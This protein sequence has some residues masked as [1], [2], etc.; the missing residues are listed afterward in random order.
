MQPGKTGE[1]FKE[2]G[3][4]VQSTSNPLSLI[5]APFP[6]AFGGM[7]EAVKT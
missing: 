1:I 7:G 3:L 6:V 4:D 2:R 5:F